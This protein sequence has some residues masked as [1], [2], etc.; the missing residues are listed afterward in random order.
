MPNF[1]F[2]IHNHQPVGNFEDVIEESYKNAYLPFLK[3]LCKHP[4]IRLSFHI[5]GYLLDWLLENHKEYIEMLQEMIRRGQV[6][7]MGG[8]YYEPI[9]A[10]IPPQDR[11]GQ[12]QMM[13]DKLE[14]LFGKRPRGMWLAERIWEPHLPR[15][16]K[17]AG[18]EYVVVDDYHFVKAG[19]K[20]EQL[21]GYYITEDLGVSLKVFPGSERLRYIIPFEAVDKFIENIRWV[22]SLGRNPAA[23][24]A[25]DGEKFG[26]WPGTH[27]W[28]HKEG[29]LKKF[30]EAIEANK[31]IIRPVTFSEYIDSNEP[32]GRVYLPTTSYMEMGE[33]ALPAEAS[34]TYTNLINE[35][36]VWPDGDRIRRF[37]QGGFWRNFFAK[38]PEANW[39]HKRMLM[40]SEE[41]AD[42]GL[43]IAELES[44]LPTPNS[45]LRTYLYMAQCNDAYWH[46]VFG[47]LYLPHLRRSVYENLIK[48]ENMSNLTP[49][50]QEADF[51]AD[52]FNEILVRTPKLNLFFS[53]HNGGSIVELDYRPKAVNVCNTLSRWEEG[54]HYKVKLQGEKQGSGETKSIH[55]L[56]ASKEE[57]LE[58][59]LFFDRQQRASLVDHFLKKEETLDAFR[60]SRY[61]ELGDF[62]HKSYD[63]RSQEENNGVVLSRD[64][65]LMGQRVKVEKRIFIKDDEIDVKYRVVKKEDEKMR[66]SDDEKKLSTSQ[67][68]NPSTSTT[69]DSELRTPNSKLPLRFGVEFNLI[70][71][72]CDGMNGFYDI[73]AKDKGL[74]SLG[75][76][77]GIRQ[78]GLVDKWT[79]IRV[80]FSFDKDTSMWRFPVETVSISEAGFE[81]IFQGSCLLF[82]WDISMDKGF[83]AGFKVKVESI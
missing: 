72:C 15:Y 4:S 35:V 8:G 25:D 41:I 33:W 63:K 11:I 73:T 28:V 32:I 78:I 42:C 52:T 47:G 69:Q 65:N 17:E 74:D 40:V 56:T 20:K 23:V 71:P 51:D 58:N 13:S 9:L 77:T 37:L 64:G 30:L 61:E 19:L 75:E 81:R 80:S 55:D 5:T 31:D 1:I 66:S 76:L 3:A 62:F 45:Q 79:K 10:V 7:M 49:M 43:R 34:G 82:F 14:E 83:E 29:W 24:F 67:L 44:K 21:A 26:T 36:K 27:Q 46:G 57:G 39:M 53:P 22:E 48:A 60:T 6:E 50:V 16:L 2:C 18:I 70:L 54:Y 12:I 59:Y 38:Y 68:L